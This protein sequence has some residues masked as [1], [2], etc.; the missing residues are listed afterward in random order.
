MAA[1]L[2]NVVTLGALDFDRLRAFYEGLGWPRVINDDD[3]VAFE[4]RGAVLA[5][6]PRAKLANDGRVEPSSDTGL[7]FTVGL[8]ATS[9]EEVDHLVEQMRA[10]DGVVTK[11]AE[12][13]EFF[14]GRSAYVSDPEGNFWEIAWAP[15][16]N[17]IVSAAKRAASGNK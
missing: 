5:V 10:H 15:D 2:A 8:M 12:D 17:A 4:L 11:D 1:P 9:R 7:R 16:S 6:F 3:F 13:A 14:E